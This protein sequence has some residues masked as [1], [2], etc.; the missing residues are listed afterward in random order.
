MSVVNA[1]ETRD[2]GDPAREAWERMRELTHDPEVLGSVHALAAQAGIIPGAAKA[3]KYLSAT[4][5]TPMRQLAAN[6]RCDTSY[7]T[8]IVDNLEEQGVARRQAHATDRRIKVVVLTPAGKE[9]ADK[10]AL[11][12]G[13]PPPAFNAL[14]AEESVVLRDLIRKLSAGAPRSNR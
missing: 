3:L 5:P 9:L 12:M 13:T 10:L 2:G 7:I 11:V 6:L 8:T 14:D 4:E 1:V